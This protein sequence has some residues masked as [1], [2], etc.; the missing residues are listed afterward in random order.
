MLTREDLLRTKILTYGR[1]REIQEKLFTLGIKWVGG[2]KKVQYEYATSLYIDSC[3]YITYMEEEGDGNS[4]YFQNKDYREI[5]LDDILGEE[6][7][8]PFK[9]F[10]KVLVRNGS[11]E[12]WHPA[13]Y[14]RYVNRKHSVMGIGK[15]IHCIPYEG[16]EELAFKN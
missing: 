7:T 1:S 15:Y 3:G 5:S 2:E 14:S 6:E 12:V 11:N 8:C 9:P 16:N 13:L 10:D 4:D